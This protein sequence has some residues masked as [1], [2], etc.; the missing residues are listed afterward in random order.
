MAN[1]NLKLVTLVAALLLAGCADLSGI[2][3]RAKLRDPASFKLEAGAQASVPTQW[4]R[5]F[6]DAQ[7]DRLV[8][9]ALADNPNLRVAQARLA[10]AQAVSEVAGAA[11]LPQVN[12]SLDATPSATRRTA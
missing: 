2:E 12:G 5:G 9:Q 4:W 10:R 11:L 7:L 3:P 1:S 8:D 6:G